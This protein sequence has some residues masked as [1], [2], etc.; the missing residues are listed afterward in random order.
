MSKIFDLVFRSGIRSGIVNTLTLFRMISSPVLIYLLFINSAAFKWLILAAFITD[1]LDGFLA[2]YW[3]VT[4]KLGAILDSLADDILFIVLL[5]AI[6]VWHPSVFT[7]HTTILSITLILFFIKMAALYLRHKKIIS[8]M[9]TYLTKAAAFMQA[10][11]FLF[12]IFFGPHSI[13]FYSAIYCTIF[14][15]AEE[16]IIISTFRILK[17]NIKGIF[18]V[19]SQM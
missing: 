5:V 14:A 19:K 9:H 7:D 15:L 1:I 16:I 10:L 6:V 2:R 17:E 3:K 8:G 4:S 12:C 18:F 13:L 11:F